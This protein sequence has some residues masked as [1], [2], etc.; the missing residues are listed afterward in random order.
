MAMPK[1]LVM[2]DTH[3][4][5]PGQSIIGLSPSKR[6]AAALDHALAAHPDAA[7]LILMGDL[8]HHGADAEYSE[9]ASILGDV[10]IPIIPML[11]NHDRRDAFQAA[12]PAAPKCAHGFVQ[13]VVDYPHHRVITLDTLDGPPYPKGHHAGHLC[14]KR[15]EWLTKALDGAAG[16]KP[17]VFA[18]HPPFETG[19]VG[20]D[21]IRLLDG[22]DLVALLAQHDAHLF[23]GHIHRTISGQ[24]NGLSWTMFKSP[25]HQGVLDLADPD[26]SL[27][28][29]EPGAYGVV[30]LPQG[31]VVAHSV[32]VLPPRDIHRDMHSA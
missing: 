17:I 32:D 26:S 2:T 15:R 21:R 31:G 19:I 10:P 3:I 28:I 14:A 11:G 25:C 23:C 5:A 7:A 22:D 18:H 4:C 9:L 13:K 6:L 12:F 29:D 24:M 20:M 30:L 1:L 27:S 16:R 8:T